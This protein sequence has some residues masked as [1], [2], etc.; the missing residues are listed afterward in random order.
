MLEF[1][2][3]LTGWRNYFDLI[4]YP[5]RVL[6]LRIASKEDKQAEKRDGE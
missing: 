5:P 2:N 4:R 1:S 6:R 3:H